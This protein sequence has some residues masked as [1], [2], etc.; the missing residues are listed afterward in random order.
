MIILSPI[1]VA[2]FLDSDGKPAVNGH[3]PEKI[4]FETP[5]ETCGVC[6]HSALQASALDSQPPVKRLD[7]ECLYHSYINSMWCRGNSLDPGCGDCVFGAPNGKEIDSHWESHAPDEGN[8][9][10]RF[11]FAWRESA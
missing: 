7:L 9:F 5:P 6:D 11:N 4:V 8:S 1:D 3:Q 2:T 10:L